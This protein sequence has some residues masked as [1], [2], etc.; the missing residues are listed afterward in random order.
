MTKVNCFTCQHFHTTWNPQ[1]PRGC[2]AY[3]FKGREMPSQTVLRTTG[4]ACLQYERKM[5]KN[6][7]STM[8]KSR[9]L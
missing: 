8:E 4:T 6:A 9:N 3:G 5:V 7:G 1:F 2:K